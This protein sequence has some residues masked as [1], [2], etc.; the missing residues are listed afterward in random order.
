M[1]SESVVEQ[2][3]SKLKNLNPLFQTLET[4]LSAASRATQQATSAIQSAGKTVQAVATLL[5][6]DEINRLKEKSS[7]SSSGSKKG[8]SGSGGDKVKTGP[9][10]DYG[11]A[12]RLEK[13]SKTDLQK[14]WSQFQV[15][16]QDVSGGGESA[17]RSLVQRIADGI[18][19]ALGNAANWVAEHIWN[20]I[21]NGWNSLGAV[22]VTVGAVLGTTAGELWSGFL[23]AWQ[24]GGT[25]VV[26]IWN[27]LTNEASTLWQQFSML[28]GTRGVGI[29]NTLTNAASTLWQQFSMLWG[30]QGVGIVNTLT[31]AATTLWQQFSTLWGTRGVGIVNTLTN[32]AA[33]LWQSFAAG[34]G[35][36]SV[37]IVNS[38]VSAASTLWQRFAS[39]WGTRSV[40]IVNTLTNSASSLWERFRSGWAG[41]TLSL[42]VTYSTNV[43]AIKRAV[44]KALGLSGWP[45]ISFAARG[46]V[47]QNPTLT[48]LGEAG[49]E[50]VVPLENNTGWMDVMAEKLGDRMGT[51]GTI[52]VPVYIGGDKVAEKVVEAVNAETR[53]TGVSP[54]YI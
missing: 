12:V 29:V 51:T 4:R 43:S 38:L 46:G 18:S 37:G 45:T 5:D 19:N 21:K 11:L 52:V 6:F 53:R 54:L 48:M 33:G 49:T 14:F 2:V 26:E 17:G 1:K 28:W 42:T 39:G 8:S 25:R 40:G 3:A 30:T 31:N 7:G 44:Y 27:T 23:S 20:P 34:W 13:P 32:G 22:G 10:E 9:T 24:G 35:T 47:F 16:F 50:A 15:G 36:R 41:R